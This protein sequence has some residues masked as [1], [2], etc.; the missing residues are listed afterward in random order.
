MGTGGV[1]VDMKTRTTQ[2]HRHHRGRTH[3]AEIIGLILLSCENTFSPGSSVPVLG[4]H[5]S[6]D[7]TE[8]AE[9]LGHSAGQQADLV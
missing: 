2:S 4:S 8:A 1:N 7:Q 3:A 6:P 5:K 9:P